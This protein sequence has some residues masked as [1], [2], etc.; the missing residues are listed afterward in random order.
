MVRLSHERQKNSLQMR[1]IRISH[2]HCGDKSVP[3]QPKQRSAEKD[4]SSKRVLAFIFPWFSPKRHH[5]DKKD[6]AISPSLH[7]PSLGHGARHH[8]TLS[9]QKPRSR[10]HAGSIRP[11][12]GTR[13]YR[14]TSLYRR[15]RRPALGRQRHQPT[16]RQ[17]YCPI[18]H[19][20]PGYRH[21]RRHGRRR[22]PL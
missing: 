14:Q 18:G 4:I 15:P 20:L 11:A 9:Q 6:T 8:P 5:Y 19:E 1:E 7:D 2:R 17:A 12:I 21:L 16:R 10:H 3:L 13:M 22:I